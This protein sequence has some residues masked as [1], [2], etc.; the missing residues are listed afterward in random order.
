MASL[1]ETCAHDTTDRTGTD[2]DE[3]RLRHERD[4]TQLL[5]RRRRGRYDALRAE[6]FFLAGVFFAGGAFF[7]VAFLAGGFFFAAAF[8][9]GDFVPERFESMLACR[10]SMRSSTLPSLGAAFSSS[11]TSSPRSFA[12]MSVV[13]S[14]V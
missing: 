5:P 1:M 7:A 6:D 14:S 13:S 11:T 8:L 9:A 10:A 12:S 2:N 4:R 3:T